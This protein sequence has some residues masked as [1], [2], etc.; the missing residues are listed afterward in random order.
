[1]HLNYMHT[2]KAVNSCR[3]DICQT[4]V[5]FSTEELSFACG[6]RT[7]LPKKPQATGR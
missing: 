5:L 7:S 1:M 2:V 3:F 6:Q 4:A